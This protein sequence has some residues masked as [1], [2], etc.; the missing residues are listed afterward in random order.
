MTAETRREIGKIALPVSLESVIQLTL[1]FVNQV[2]VG[3]LGTAT[4]AAVGLSNN[5]IFIGILCLNVLGSGCA[6]MASKA[7][8]R[9]D[10]EGLA[11]IA[12]FSLLFAF[13]LS[14]SI[15]LPL[16]LSGEGFLRLVGASTELATIGGPYLSLY[17]L[18]LPLITA[19][20]VMT[21]T[22][23]TI[24][25]ARL[26]LVV[27]MSTLTLTPPLAWVFV[28]QLGWGAEGAAWAAILTQLLRVGLLAGYL[29]AS[30][31]GIRFSWPDWPQARAIL[32]EMTPLVL[33]LFITEVVFSSGV[34]LFAL[35]AERLGTAELAAF[36]IVST[37][38]NIFIVGAVGFNAAATILTAKA[39]GQAN[40]SEVW[41]WSGS[42]WRFGFFAAIGMGVLFGLSALMVPL[43]FPN[44]T[45][46]VQQ[47]AIWGAVLNAVF[48]PVKASNMIGFGI[49]A[50][51]GDTRYLLFS[52]FLTVFVVGLPLAY[53]LAFP[54]G[55]GIWG[56][57][58]GRLLGEETVR[59][60]I[61]FWRYRTGVWFKLEPAPGSPPDSRAA[62]GG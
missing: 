32:R 28:T 33:P 49:L 47:T 56:I 25:R 57:F 31:W 51:G 42:V 30:R 2:I 6:I 41:R 22:F 39:I 4:I 20:V 43:L 16:F 40:A 53:L 10:E 58:L 55:M 11:R 35:L 26:P 50:T 1:S 15:A 52:D 62:G 60:L 45:P 24:G 3:T 8:G 27:T 44:T 48:M 54:L 46:A 7:R 9:G 61:L 14:L 38:E 17:A 29:F 18:T 36:Q 37:L 34:F 59:I 13:V 5:A 12:T 23:R 19:S 21:Q